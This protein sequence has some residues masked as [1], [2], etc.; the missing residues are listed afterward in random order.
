MDWKVILGSAV[1]GALITAIATLRTHSRNIQIDNVIK[2]RTKWR[3]KIREKAKDVTDAFCKND[4]DRL[5]GLKVDFT[6]LINPVDKTGEDQEIIKEIENLISSQNSEALDRF[7]IRVALL[8]KHDWERAKEECKS[9]WFKD[10]RKVRLFPLRFAEPTR[11]T[12]SKYKAKLKK[13]DNK[14]NARAK[15]NPRPW[16]SI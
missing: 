16:D 2:E 6:L 1:I 9:I 3:D 5:I 13:E 7:R 15:V 14:A 4:A 11:T 12:Y 10:L 8:L